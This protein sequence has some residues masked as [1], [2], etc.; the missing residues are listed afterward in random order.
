M[1]L[2]ELQKEYPKGIAVVFSVF[3][4]DKRE[5][6]LDLQ[7]LDLQNN[8]FVINVGHPLYKKIE[9]STIAFQYHV[10]RVVTS[11]LALH[12]FTQKSMTIQ[13]FTELQTEIL[14]AVGN[15]LWL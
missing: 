12:I 8:Q 9:T 7:N 4:K 10:A 13:E 5:G 3:P 2:E 15:K 1:A 6:W 14:T 11:I